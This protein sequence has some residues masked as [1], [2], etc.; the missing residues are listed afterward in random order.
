MDES[1]GHWGR[2]FAEFYDYV[3]PYRDRRDVGFFVAMARQAGGPV[4]ELGCGT[5]R[6]LIPTARAGVEIV[7]LDVSAP[8]LAVCREKLSRKPEEVQARVRLVR[9]DRFDTA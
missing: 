8:M 4:L 5:G 1:G 9:A 2:V 7:G 6:V 3:I